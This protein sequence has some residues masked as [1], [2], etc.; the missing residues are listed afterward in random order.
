VAARSAAQLQCVIEDEGTGV[1][2]AAAGE[3]SHY[4]MEIKTERA[5]CL[6]GT[7]V[8]GA[9]R[10]GGM[11]VL[12]A[13]SDPDH[14]LALSRDVRPGQSNKSIARALDLSH[15]TVKLHLWHILS[16]LNL[17]SRVEAAVFAVEQRV[18]GE[19]GSRR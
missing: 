9:K 14:V 10:G 15:D 3:G 13:R 4:G 12:A 19:G 16:R 1:P 18:R 7:L 6:G 11:E 5:R 2:L 8:V 17:S